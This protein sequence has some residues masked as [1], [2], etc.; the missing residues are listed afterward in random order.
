MLA[1][2]VAEEMAAVAPHV[3]LWCRPM[4][5]S[6]IAGATDALRTVDGAIIPHGFLHDLPHLDAY[7][8]QWVLVADRANRRLRGRVDLSL[9]AEVDWVLPFHQR[10]AYALP[11]VRQLELLGVQLRVVVTVD[12][13]LALP[14]FVAGTDRVT[15]IPE[16]LIHHI[17]PPT[18]F[19]I[20]ESPFDAVPL[21]EAFWWHPSLERDP[22]HR[23][24]RSIVTRAGKRLAGEGPTLGADP[25]S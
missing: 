10:G 12:G 2:A 22:G 16:R 11:P 24:F 19:Q 6:L 20:L 14:A 18:S 21:A 5:D 4:S 13:F 15:I 17:A 3:R 7:I 9:L 23:W 1:R 25:R 8:D